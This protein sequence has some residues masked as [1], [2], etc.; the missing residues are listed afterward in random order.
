MGGVPQKMRS[1]QKVQGSKSR[2]Q[3]H[4]RAKIFGLRLSQIWTLGWP[5]PPETAHYGVPQKMRTLRKVQ[6]SKSRCQT[7]NRARIFGLRLTQIWTLGWP[8]PPE[9]AH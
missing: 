7:Y 3:T 4:N 9:T 1:P 6:G 2:C 8:K 5:K